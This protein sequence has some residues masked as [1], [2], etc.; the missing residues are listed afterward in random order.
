[1]LQIV[2]VT[3]GHYQYISEIK[4]LVTQEVLVSFDEKENKI[5]LEPMVE[6]IGEQ[7]MVSHYVQEGPD[8]Y[9]DYEHAQFINKVDKDENGLWFIEWSE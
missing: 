6:H 3:D 7:V 2:I 1:M 5:P 9:F 4:N 8:R